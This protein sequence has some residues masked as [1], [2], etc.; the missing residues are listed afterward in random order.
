MISG[1]LKEELEEAEIHMF[2]DTIAIRL[3][4]G[5]KSDYRNHVTVHIFNGVP[6]GRSA[7]VGSEPVMDTEFISGLLKE[8]LNIC[9]TSSGIINTNLFDDRKRKEFQIRLEKILFFN[10][11]KNNLLHE[12][13]S[14]EDTLQ[15]VNELYSCFIVD[16]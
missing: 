11:M 16:G 4:F 7:Y 9:T 13:L 12:K 14:H 10:K 2:N 15:V 3:E 8:I 6:E 5:D 1:F